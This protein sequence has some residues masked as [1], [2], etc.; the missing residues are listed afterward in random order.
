MAEQNPSDGAWA[1]DAPPLQEAPW[2][3]AYGSLMWRPGFAF[4]EVRRAKLSGWHRAFCIV[5]RHHRGTP[6]QPGLVLGLDRG[7]SCHGVAY[8]IAKDAAPQVLRE[9]RAREQVSG[10]YR[11][12]IVG[13]DLDGAAS[14]R[15]PALAYLAECRH[16]SFMRGLSAERQ[17]WIIAQAKGRSGRNI[18]YLAAT[19]AEFRRLGIRER[20]LE[21]VLRLSG[22][23]LSSRSDLA[24]RCPDRRA[25]VSAWPAA[26]RERL[27]KMRAFEVKRFAH[28]KALPLAFAPER[29]RPAGGL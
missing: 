25:T 8:R 21:V 7:G 16:P 28:R 23:M 22:G 10:V 27:A 14:A 24:R 15:V 17:A 13:I 26:G 19:L 6:A 11:E 12:R 18:D 20:E 4:M 9:L 5:S 1:E 3:F 2:V 29:A